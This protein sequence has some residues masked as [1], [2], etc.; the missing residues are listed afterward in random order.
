MNEA[1]I[2]FLTESENI[3]KIVKENLISLGKKRIYNLRHL[4]L[5]Y[6]NLRLSIKK[7]KEA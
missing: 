1:K 3:G 5:I 4:G 6:L 7:K 2:L